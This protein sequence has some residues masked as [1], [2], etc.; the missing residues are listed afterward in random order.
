M[1][2]LVQTILPYVLLYKYVALFIICFLAS[3][4][5][6]IPSGSLL[7]ASAAFASQ[8]YLNIA[9]VLISAFLG[10]VAGDN[11]GYFLARY[12]GKQIL[13]KI[14]FRK[15]LQSSKFKL[16]SQRVAERPGFI[17]FISR[18]EVLATLS[19]NLIAG[20]AKTSYKKYLLFESIGTIAQVCMYGILGFLFGST[21]QAVNALIGKFTI[22]VFIG[23]A[24]IVVV[25]WRRLMKPF[26]TKVAV[27]K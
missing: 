16:I 23:I 10:S 2:F 6:P 5:V 8:G 14:G 27:E 25:F 24:L 11:L 21:W 13:S 4:A 12:Y 26:K 20:L 3:I 19:V 7:M 17:I 1:D 15:I 18:F 22:V 9:W